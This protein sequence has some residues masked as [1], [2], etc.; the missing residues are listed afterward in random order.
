MKYRRLGRAGV[1]VS[2]ISFGTW[3]T[4]GGQVDLQTAHACLDA[5]WDSG[6]NFYDTADV[7][8]QGAAEQVLGAWLRKKP[9]KDYVV[10]T[11]VFFP[12]GE[13]ENDKGLS[14][15]HLVE[16]C[17]ASLR[18]LNVEYVDLY[19]CHRFDETVRLDET[20]R[21]MDDLIRQGKILYW[22][23][24]QWE[25][26]QIEQACR[27]AEKRNADLPVSNQPRY[28]LLSRE[29][30]P[31]VIPTCEREEIGQIVWSPLA[32]GLLTGKYGAD[33]KARSGRASD[34]RVNS[35][36]LPWMTEENLRRAERFT[37]LA[38]ELGH[39]PAQLALAWCLRLPNIA[40]AIIGASRP[41][42]VRENAAASGLELSA[43]L[44]R[45]IDSL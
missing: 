2:E 29:I 27:V 17:E 34:A 16:S 42:Q 33:A 40:S 32:Q 8:N 5:A 18:R 13:G 37:A 15:K 45:K 20:V 30:E 12:T 9:R 21:A 11:K 26:P 44:L 14:R 36:L 1:R 23:V 43:E 41:E 28:N 19:Q 31:Q 24:S 4:F 39:T 7:Y 10:A 25:A 3:L 38:R 6:I 35:F 22:G